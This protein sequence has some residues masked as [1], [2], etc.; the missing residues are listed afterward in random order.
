MKIINLNE[1]GLTQLII[2]L[3]LSVLFQI[4]DILFET[5]SGLNYKKIDSS[6]Y[7]MNK[8]KTESILF[9]F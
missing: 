1:N 3:I 2:D 5:Y 4:F 8:N 7:L 6:L 9:L